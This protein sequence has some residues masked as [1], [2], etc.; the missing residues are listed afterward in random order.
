[1]L[2][3]IKINVSLHIL[4]DKSLVRLLWAG[5]QLYRPFPEKRWPEFQIL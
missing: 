1:M 3:V 5:Q 2:I 4:A